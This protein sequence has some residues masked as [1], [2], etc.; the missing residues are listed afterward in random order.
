MINYV[1]L[2]RDLRQEDENEAGGALNLLCWCLFLSLVSAISYFSCSRVRGGQFCNVAV[3]FTIMF[4]VMHDHLVQ[5]SFT[6][7]KHHQVGPQGFPDQARQT[8]N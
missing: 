5:K 6:K 2:H 8:F 3:G 7:C 4:I 1:S